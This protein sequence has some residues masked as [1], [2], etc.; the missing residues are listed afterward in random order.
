MPEHTREILSMNPDPS[1]QW[2]AL[3]DF[4]GSGISPIVF[5]TLK[6]AIISGLLLLEVVTAEQ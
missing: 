4:K 2:K 5:Q 1:S 3:N 6:L